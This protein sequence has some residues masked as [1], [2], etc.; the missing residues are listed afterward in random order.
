MCDSFVLRTGEKRLREDKQWEVFQ[1]ESVLEEVTPRRPPPPPKEKTHTHSSSSMRRLLVP[2]DGLST[3]T[4]GG[5]LPCFH[6][7]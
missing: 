3:V 4:V 1:G 2:A 5:F 6:Q 7:F